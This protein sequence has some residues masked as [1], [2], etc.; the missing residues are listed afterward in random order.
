[1]QDRKSCSARDGRAGRGPGRA[2][3]AGQAKEA[4]LFT[5]ARSIRTDPNARKYRLLRNMII[6]LHVSQDTDHLAL[7]KGHQST[8]ISVSG[9]DLLSVA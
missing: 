3:G 2:G 1:M 6:C 9:H 8:T 7:T 5:D 4:R